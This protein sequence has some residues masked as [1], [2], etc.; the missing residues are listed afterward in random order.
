MAAAAAAWQGVATT[1]VSHPRGGV[2]EKSR[3]E[4]LLGLQGF[5]FI[6]ESPKYNHQNDELTEIQI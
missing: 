5:H 2:E 3:E 1:D 4:W 6:P